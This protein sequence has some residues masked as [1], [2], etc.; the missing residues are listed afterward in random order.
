[1]TLV[2][3][4]FPGFVMGGAQA[5]F[6]A[7]ANHHGR[8]LRHAIVSMNGRLDCR[9]RLDPG[10]SVT[11]PDVRVEKGDPLGTLR[12]LRAVLRALRPDVLLTHNFGSIDWALA[13]LPPRPGRPRH[14]H[15]EDGFGPDEGQRQFARRVWARRL[16]LRRATVVLPSRVLFG[17][18]LTIWRLAP[19]RLRYLPNGVD[20]ARFARPDLAA[21]GVRVPPGD[22]PVIGTVAALRPEKNIARLLRAVALLP[23]A[24]L[25]VV[26]D[27][28]ERAALQALAASLGLAGRVAFTGH[29]ADPAEAY[30]H[31][32]VFAL[33]SD[34]EQMPLS[35]LE[36]MAAGL[37]V[38]ATD[39]GDVA[40]M[41]AAANAPFVVAR[42]ATA[43]AAALA[44]LLAD[45]GLRRQ[46]GTANRARAGQD[47]DQADMLAA[48]GGLLGAGPEGACQSQPT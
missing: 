39:V 32:D 18:A 9:E 47:Y 36:A 23:Q 43:L 45:A 29:L 38:A 42:D 28:P 33:S 37:P 15:V 16:A 30:R 21:A 3:S 12:R 35:V 14:V 27:G 22:G 48:W 34:T 13:D 25:L 5:R 2:L 11:F 41:V 31:M 17:I 44:Q 46:V 1:M 4:V 8:A 20:V 19:A 40:A 10:L 7:V 24:R 26:G 6:C